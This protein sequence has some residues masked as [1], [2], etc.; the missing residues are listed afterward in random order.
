MRQP[1]TVRHYRPALRSW[2]DARRYHG[3][4]YDQE[5]NARP[6]HI[7]VRHTLLDL[8]SGQTGPRNADLSTSHRVSVMQWKQQFLQWSN[9]QDKQISVFTADEKEKVCCAAHCSLAPSLVDLRPP[10]SPLFNPDLQ[11]TGAAGIV[12]STYSMIANT[13]KRSHSSA[14]MMEFLTSRE[15]GFLLLDEVHVAP[16]NVFRRAVSTIK[17]HAK[18]GLTGACNMS[19]YCARYR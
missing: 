19:A 16:A 7:W 8:T 10:P 14:K 12:V 18:L 9:I 2:K 3:R 6:L 15:W 5:V 13:S 17:T 4:V 11:F 1:S